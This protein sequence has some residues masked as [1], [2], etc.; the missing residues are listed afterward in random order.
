M[1]LN[2]FARGGD[3]EAAVDWGEGCFCRL[4]GFFLTCGTGEPHFLEHGNR[5]GKAYH[6]NVWMVNIVPI[7]YYLLLHLASLECMAYWLVFPVMLII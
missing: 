5:H 4:G 3:E 6:I 7:K 1:V 2:G